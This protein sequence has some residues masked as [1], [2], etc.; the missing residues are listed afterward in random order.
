MTDLSCCIQPVEDV[1]ALFNHLV[2]SALIALLLVYVYCKL[3]Y[4]SVSCTTNL[5]GYVGYNVV[6]KNIVLMESTYSFGSN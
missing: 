3:M 2:L 6:G 1:T 4:V 5:V